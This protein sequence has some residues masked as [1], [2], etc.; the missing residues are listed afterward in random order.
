M[1]ESHD[2]SGKPG[3]STMTDEPSVIA[4]HPY[5]VTY[6]LTVTIRRDGEGSL[7]LGG[8]GMDKVHHDIQHVPVDVARSISTFMT[9][10]SDD[11][12]EDVV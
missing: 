1:V 5:D 4:E 10:L 12:A 2:R 3:G 7:T 6:S 8:K 9:A 11:A